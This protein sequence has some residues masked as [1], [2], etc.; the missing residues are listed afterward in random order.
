MWA[1]KEGSVV[2]IFPLVPLK[3]AD[4]QLQLLGNGLYAVHGV[5]I[6]HILM[7]GER[8]PTAD[9]WTDHPAE[10]N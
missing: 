6:E 10:Q 2:S 5:Y 8:K 1:E 7:A 9:V 3:A 4:S